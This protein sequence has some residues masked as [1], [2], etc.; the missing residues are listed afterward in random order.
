MQRMAPGKGMGDSA[1]SGFLR[2]LLGD[3][4]T[5]AERVKRE[6]SEEVTEDK[7]KPIRDDEHRFI[8]RDDTLVCATCG[9]V[10]GRGVSKRMQRKLRG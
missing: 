9:F 3:A 6:W 7:P 4:E 1:S 8:W 5:P 2:L 10:I